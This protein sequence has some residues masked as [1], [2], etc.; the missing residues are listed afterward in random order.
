MEV[1]PLTASQIAWYSKHDMSASTAHVRY[2]RS[3]LNP[4]HG[5][6]QKVDERCELSPELSASKTKMSAF[7]R[8]TP[9]HVLATLVVSQARVPRLIST[10]STMFVRICWA[11]RAQFCIHSTFKFVSVSGL[12][13]CSMCCKFSEGRGFVKK[14]KET[15]SEATALTGAWQ[16]PIAFERTMVGHWSTFPHEFCMFIALGP[17]LHWRTRA[18]GTRTAHGSARHGEKQRICTVV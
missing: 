10:M 6:S 4:R 14:E 3:V 7:P 5:Q 16:V 13:V 15:S 8:S 11:C 2:Q 18:A 9:V 1:L 12:T 17:T